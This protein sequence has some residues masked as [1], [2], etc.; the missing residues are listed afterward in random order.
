M[1]TKFQ[2]N[3]IFARMKD[4]MESLPAIFDENGETIKKDRNEIKIIQHEDLK[5]CIKSFNRVTVL[6]RY[7]YSW[8]RSTK[9]KRSYKVARK[10]EKRNI[11]T[12]APVGYVEVYG[13]WGILE[14]AFYVSLYQEHDYDMADVLDK[15]IAKQEV[16][17]T[18]FAE[19]MAK[20][21]HPAG[22][23]HNDLSP[24]NVL[25]NSKENGEWSFSFIDLNRLVFKNRISSFQGLSNLKKMTNKP[26]ALSL[27]AEQYALAAKKNPQFYS[28]LLMRD[29]L[30]FGIRRSRIKRILHIFKPRKKVVKPP[31]EDR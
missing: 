15:S 12:P 9:A 28:I 18:A 22:A 26:V 21:V 24:G 25:I 19:Y 13:R 4:F 14:K 3:P 8:F 5:L 27:M 30:F 17:L 1:K 29:N 2:I 23:W 10:L 7:I 16:I 20:V 6:N 31:Q 11:N